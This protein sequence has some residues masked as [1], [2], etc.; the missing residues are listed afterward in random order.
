MLRSSH[1]AFANRLRLSVSVTTTRENVTYTTYENTSRFEG[2]VFQNVAIFN[3]TQPVTVTDST[4]TRF[5]EVGGTSVRNPVALAR[6]VANVGNATRTL[7][8]SSAEF[9]LTSGLTAKVAVGLDH[10]HRLRH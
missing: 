5:Y 6:Q 3:P 7:G 8:N 10:S 1:H 2:G 4:G 9:D